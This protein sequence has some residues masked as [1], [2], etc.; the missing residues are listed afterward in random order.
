MFSAFSGLSFGAG[1]AETDNPLLRESSVDLAP[2]GG[3]LDL[4]GTGHYDIA[5]GKK[6]VTENN[7]RDVLEDGGSVKYDPDTKTLT[8]NNPR[9]TEAYQETYGAIH[10]NADGVTVQGT[11]HMT[12]AVSQYG[13]YAVNGAVLNGN[14][15]FYG[16][17]SGISAT[18]C[19]IVGGTIKGVGTGADSEGLY[20]D[21]LFIYSTITKLE[22]SGALYIYSG[23]E[24]VEA[25]SVNKKAIYTAWFY[26]DDAMV[27]TTPEGGYRIDHVVYHSD[28]TT[29]AK[30]II[31]E[32]GCKMTFNMN[33]HGEAVRA[34]AV[35]EG[36]TIEKPAD[37]VEEGYDFLGWYA[38]E[39]FTQEYDF[40][41][42]MTGDVDVYAKWQIIEY[43]VSFV[44][45][46]HGEAPETRNY[47]Y[48]SVVTEP[49][50]PADPGYA[51][52]GLFTDEACTK[53][54]DFSAGVKAEL[55][56]YAKW[57][58]EQYSVVV[59]ADNGTEAK[60]TEDKKF[61]YG[62]EYTLPECI[63]AIPE[64]KVFDQWDKGA[65]GE[66]ISITSD[67]TV[68]AVWRKIYIVG[69]VDGNDMVNNRDSVILDRYIA[70]W[71]GYDTRI[72]NMKAADLNRDGVV[73]N[74]DAIILDRYVAVWDGY[75]KYIIK[76]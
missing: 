8:L 74:R 32:R 49:E 63:F 27:I 10:I 11:F 23:A 36:G 53:A 1:A 73:N 66:T 61:V 25:V 28:G 35:M 76:V 20:C 34:K 48:G 72:T 7:Y 71:V 30:H 57:E 39:D 17:E 56:L 67:T 24:K 70:N 13:F 26:I 4:A 37:P 60:Y 51:F 46:G 18:T 12:G 5:V 6:V 21:D 41:V 64:G 50:T 44:T 15:T 59:V 3:D 29:Q 19:E 38:D 58:Q 22:M 31:I 14:F 40:T 75:D 2:V 69:D 54:Y 16:T 33:G 47:E 52:L 55:I 43:P 68:T 62:E 65:V 45:N 42:P 9:I